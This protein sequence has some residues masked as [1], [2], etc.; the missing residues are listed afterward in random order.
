M[1]E[2]YCKICGKS[3]EECED[4]TV[5]RFCFVCPECEIDPDPDEIKIGFTA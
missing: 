4:N 2:R 1:E 5:K 3:C